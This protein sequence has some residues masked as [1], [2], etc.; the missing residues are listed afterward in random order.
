MPLVSFRVGRIDIL[1]HHVGI[2]EGKEG[3]KF[4]PLQGVE[5]V[6]DQ[7]VGLAKA[8]HVLL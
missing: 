8:F 4:A 7:L 5:L 3:V 1:D 2:E 6:V